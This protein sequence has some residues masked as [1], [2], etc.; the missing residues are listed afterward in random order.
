MGNI[1]IHTKPPHYYSIL[2]LLLNFLLLSASSYAAAFQGI[3]VT[4]TVLDQKLNDPLVGVTILEKGTSNG[5]VTDFD[6]KFTLTVTN[7]NSILEFSYIGFETQSTAV[8]SQTEFTIYLEE[9]AVGLDQIIIVGYAEQKR[10]DVTGAISS[11]SEE[12]FNQG[13]VDAPE[14]LLQAKIPGVRVTSSSGE[15]GASTTL[16]IRG[17]GS[18]RSGDSPLYVIDGVPISNEATSPGSGNL[19][20]S[21]I[22]TTAGSSNPLSFLN[23]SDIATVDVLKDASATAIYGSRGANGVVLITTKKG[24]SGKSKIDYNT[25]VGFSTI[26]NQLDVLTTSDFND[27]SGIDTDWQDEI[28]RTAITQNHNISYGTGTDRSSL[29]VSLGLLDQE[30]IIDRNELKRYTGRVNSSVYALKENKLK[31]DFNLIASQTQNYSVPRA[32]VA[33]TTGELITNTLSALP[34]RPVLDQSGNFSS[35][36]TNPVGLLNS[37]NDETITNRVLGNISASYKIVS[38]LKYQINFGVDLSNSK[39]E[40]ELIPNILEGVAN[41]GTYSVADVQASNVLF[42]NFATYSFNKNDHDFNF[43]VGYAYQEFNLEQSRSTYIGYVFPN[44]SALDNPTNAPFLNGLPQGSDNTTSLESVFARVNYAFG[45]RLDVTASIRAD[46]TS[47]FI[48]DN[49]WGYFP[50]FAASYN[51]IN[52]D[53]ATTKIDYLK[54]RVGWGQTGNQNV[55]G[56]PTE[57]A[58]DFVQISDTEVGLTKVAEGNPDLEWEVSNQFNVGIDF[59]MFDDRL[60]GN[61][62]YFN[63]VNKKLILF[64]ASEPPAVSG[65]WINL[66]GDIKNSGVELALG[67]KVIEQDDFNWTFD[68]NGT[69]ISNEVSL[70]EGE[71]YITGAIS[72]RS[73][74]GSFVQVIR[75]GEELGSFL[76][77]T[78]NPDGT[79]SDEKTIQGSGIPDFTYGFSTTLDYKSFDLSLN[80]SGVAGNKIYNNTAHFLNNEGNNVTRELA[81]ETNQIPTGASDYF[82]EDGD[83]LRLNNATFGYTVNT[84]SINFLEK[85]RLYVTGQNLFVIT[86]YNGYDPEVNTPSAANGILSY[87]IDFATYPRARTFL[88]GLNAS[89]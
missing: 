26:A 40:Q 51:L 35:G 85:L 55:P 29:R 88:V 22:P 83:F 76:L 31:L 70:R 82:L 59:S 23:P 10:V 67:Y 42:E 87:G 39:R 32:D 86:R 41:D 47:K 56:N 13:I 11:I 1:S 30:G 6:G 27:P 62:D 74:D 58:F 3:Q 52:P 68:L 75:D 78:A 15:P 5:A 34:T 20:G 84:E 50:A 25:Y 7:T 73:L 19:S 16:T 89:F 8:G 33:D 17:A 21:N 9:S 38:N 77:P 43:L 71:E 79:V 64:V 53:N 72:G 28:F 18:L 61:I 37:W 54:A 46:G 12:S 80:F 63:K 48:D 24:K 36:P 66:P 81:D 69:F 44:I 14:Y 57:D 4:G 45:N 2:I 49:K 65:E 60:Y